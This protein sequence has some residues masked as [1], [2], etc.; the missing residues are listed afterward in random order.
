MNAKKII[1]IVVVIAVLGTLIAWQ[2]ELG[3]FSKTQTTAATSLGADYHP[4]V[5]TDANRLLFYGDAKRPDKA[6]WHIEQTKPLLQL[7]SQYYDN[8]KKLQYFTFKSGLTYGEEQMTFAY[9][10]QDADKEPLQLLKYD[11]TVA[12]DGTVMATPVP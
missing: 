9:I 11:I 7:Q 4:V 5:Q 3:P 1:G 12:E 10:N 2:N 8:D 6:N